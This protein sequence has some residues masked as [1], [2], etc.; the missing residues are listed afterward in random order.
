V[1]SLCCAFTVET[2]PENTSAKAVL[3]I[4]MLSGDDIKG[5][6]LEACKKD[7]AAVFLFPWDSIDE[8]RRRRFRHVRRPILSVQCVH[9]RPFDASLIAWTLLIFKN[10]ERFGPNAH[11]QTQLSC[12]LVVS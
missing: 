4:A 11:F 12:T 3:T 9:A 1:R 6:S 7:M 10:S 2:F 5:A 8:I